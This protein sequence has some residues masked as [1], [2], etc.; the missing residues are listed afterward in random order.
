MVYDVKKLSAK[1]MALAKELFVFLQKEEGIAS[2]AISSDEYLKD[3]LSREDFYVIVA[4]NNG[5]VIGGLTAY[6][7]PRFKEEVKELFLYEMAVN[8]VYKKNGVAKE[9]IE[10]TKKIAS[11]KG[12]REMFVGTSVRNTAAMRLF[13]KTGGREENK[14]WYV[15][16]LD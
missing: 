13:E 5:S 15:Y 7:L 11:E 16:T 14:A 8:Q 12:V 4:L 3:I 2:P 10:F 9:I 1:D 6:E